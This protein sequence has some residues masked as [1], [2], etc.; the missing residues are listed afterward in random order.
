MATEQKILGV[1]GG[2]GL[3][4]LAGIHIEQTLEVDTP[5]GKPSS[6]L[7]IGQLNQ[8][9][10]V[11]IARHGPSH[12]IPPHQVNYRANI[13]ALKEAGVS[14]IIA[15]NAVGGITE[16]YS[17][18][19]IALPDQIID[20]TWGREHTYS[21]G[22]LTQVQHIDFSYPYC[23]SL[24]TLLIKAS[25]AAGIDI[26]ENATYGATQGPRLETAAEINRMQIDGCDLVGM[27]AMPEAAL[28]KELSL[29]YANLSLV[30]NWAAGKTAGE[31]TMQEI[32]A[33]LNQGMK[34]VE[35]IL[36]AL[37]Y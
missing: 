19:T 26:V 33:H 15:V 11:F 16:A 6:P 1:I 25:K 31:I 2:S 22:E 21:A 18:R 37:N 17:P 12:T 24:R 10:A 29:C 35:S 8:S 27:T 7:I 9:R 4:Q 36:G 28:A 5:Y 23:Q 13:W 30:V 32:E 14:D 20:Y 34:R 3:Y